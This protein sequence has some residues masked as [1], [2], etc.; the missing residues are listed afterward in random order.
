MNSAR[1]DLHLLRGCPPRVTQDPSH[2]VL[3]FGDPHDPNQSWYVLSERFEEVW[4]RSFQEPSSAI[5]G[6]QIG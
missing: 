4:F 6:D 2:F 1:L 5:G 3:N